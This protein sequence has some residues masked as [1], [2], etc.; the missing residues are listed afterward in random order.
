MKKLWHIF[1]FIAAMLLIVGFMLGVWFG[2][3]DCGSDVESID[4]H[5]ISPP[6]EDQP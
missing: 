5:K 6:A 3:Q 4:F 2:K 1:L